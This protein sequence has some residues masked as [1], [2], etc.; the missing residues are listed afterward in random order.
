[1][2]KSKK[3]NVLFL[4]DNVKKYLFYMMFPTVFFLVF[5]LINLNNIN[6]ITNEFGDYAINALQIIRAKYFKEFLGPY[7]RFGFN[8]PGPISYYYYA[9]MENVLFFLKSDYS[10]HAVAQFISNY[11]FLLTTLTIIY[12][13]FEQKYYTIIYFMLFLFTLTPFDSNIFVD[14][15]PPCLLIFPLS[16]F[17]LSSARLA[18]GNA[19][20]ML[21]LVISAVVMTHNYLSILIITISF[22]C[23]SLL[24]FIINKTKLRRNDF[25][26]IFVSGLFVI[27]SSFPILYQQFVYP[28][29]NLTKIYTFFQSYPFFNQSFSASLDYIINFYSRPITQSVN[30]DP[31]LVM[32]LLIIL[33][34]INLEKGKKSFTNYLILFNFIG[35]WLSIFAASKVIGELDTHYFWFEFSFAALFYFASVLGI[36]K[37]FKLMRNMFFECN[38]NFLKIGYIL[39]RNLA[40]ILGI[41][42][43]GSLTFITVTYYKMSNSTI[44]SYDHIITVVDN[45]ITID[46]LTEAIKPEKNKTYLLYWK[47]GGVHN[48]QFIPATGVALKLIRLNCNVCIT[49]EW[50]I[51]FGSDLKCENKSNIYKVSFFLTEK[52][53]ENIDG[54]F[55][56]M[57]TFHNTTLG[58]GEPL[59]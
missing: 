10:K 41:L 11:F 57:F 3:S 4:D 5:L 2:F 7:S 46:K 31:Y 35:L 38:L 21:P 55:E 15:W 47:N 40:I 1:M 20:Y 52:Y 37:L 8:H 13:S 58:F 42:L 39:R 44:T 14:L 51:E 22:S 29:G 27:L 54:K 45:T 59:E 19:K 50:N 56:R 24:L 36:I 53:D 34:L 12:K 43:V 16:V 17:V 23:I 30:V 28:D 32:L 49:D 26:Y 33:S 25:Y 6:I 18:T 9:F 48:F